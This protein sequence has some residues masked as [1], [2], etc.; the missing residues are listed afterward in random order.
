MTPK[1]PER[2]QASSGTYSTLT[3]PSVSVVLVNVAQV[4][5]R[6][7]L[8]AITLAGSVL[9]LFHLR[10][11]YL[12]VFSRLAGG[13]TQVARVYLFVDKL[14]VIVL[15]VLALVYAIGGESYLTEAGTVRALAVR[16]G[17]LFGPLPIAYSTSALV[18]AAVQTVGVP[19][20]VEIVAFLVTVA[21][22]VVLLLLGRI[23]P[24]GRPVT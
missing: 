12:V 3:K 20:A 2:N 17:T 19:P 6:Y 5:L 18:R 10:E 23:I 24:D 15:G 13:D 11:T 16:F 4:L 1:A 7:L 21:V 8:W 9:L 14:A 22:G